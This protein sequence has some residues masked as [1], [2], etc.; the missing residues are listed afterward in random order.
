MFEQI[1]DLPDHVIGLK[2]TGK[3]TASDY[4][5]ILIPLVEEKLKSHKRIDCLCVIENRFPGAEP[6]AMWEDMRLGLSNMNHWGRIA[7]VTD[8]HWIE[9]SISLFKIFWP[10]HLRHFE[11][12]DYDKAKNWV[13]EHHRAS[14]EVEIDVD[15]GLLILRPSQDHALTEYDFELISDIA[16]SYLSEHDS[17]YGIL[18]S[19]RHFPGWQGFSAMMS[20]M[21][22]VHDHHRKIERIA[23]VTNSPMGKFADHIADHFVRAE[24]KSYEYDQYDIALDWLNKRPAG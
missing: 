1:E 20:H 17:I 14:V 7:L 15:H 5:A 9:S 24:I 8:I 23:V 11:L 19:S 12:G 6:A 4:R 16:D 3:I 10:G 18:I 13:C 22:F 21:K 2:I